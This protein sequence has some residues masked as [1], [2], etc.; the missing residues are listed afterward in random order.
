MVLWII[1]AVMTAAAVIAALWPFGRKSDHSRG[2]SDRL[3]YQDQLQE[4]ERDH[5]AGLIGEAEADSAR[6]EISRRLLAAADEEAA[7]SKLPASLRNVLRRRAAAAA[8]IAIV[9]AVALGLYLKLGSPD[10]PGQ[11]AFARSSGT[12]ES[13]AAGVVRPG[14]NGRLPLAKDNPGLRAR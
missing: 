7:P 9:P 8:A 2:G 12:P 4:I 10:L 13:R 3:V 6:V 1:F 11:S 5:T 14:R